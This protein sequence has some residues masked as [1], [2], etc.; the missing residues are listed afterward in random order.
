MINVNRGYATMSA[1]SNSTGKNRYLIV[2]NGNVSQHLQ[3]YFKIKN[4][5]I[6]NWSRKSERSFSVKLSEDT[7][8]EIVLLAISDKA[9]NP[10]LEKHK[11]ILKKKIC[12]HFSGALNTMLAYGFHPLMTFSKNSLYKLE[13]YESILFV[14]D[15]SMPFSEI[16]P[17]LNNN[18]IKI[19]PEHKGYYHALCVMANNFTT[20]L[21]S[22]F[23]NEMQ[24]RY[25]A[26]LDNLMPFLNQTLNNLKKDHKKALTGPI[27]RKDNITIQKNLDALKTDPFYEI[28]KGFVNTFVK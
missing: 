28:Y 25:K 3:H 7:D 18:C 27:A 8:I 21:W 13:M 26:P 20:L 12:V 4:I 2:G 23:F 5:N 11:D 24:T 6:A 9:I 16:F 14:Q 19:D 17:S 22:K 10:F 1:T 15:N